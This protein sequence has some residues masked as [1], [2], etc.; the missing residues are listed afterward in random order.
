MNSDSGGGTSSISISGL[1]EDSGVGEGGALPQPV[2]MILRG[3]ATQE[4]WFEEGCFITEW[5]NSPDDPALSIARARVMPGVTTRLH[6]LVGVAERYVILEGQGRVE[7][8]GRPGLVPAI[9]VVR[10]PHEQGRPLAEGDEVPAR[11]QE[12]RR[13]LGQ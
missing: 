7:L 10:P 5:L 12:L 1:N 3:R 9:F 13:R 2:P 6:R 11:G 8:V 4:Y